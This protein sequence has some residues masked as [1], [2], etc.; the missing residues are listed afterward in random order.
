MYRR[1]NVQ[2]QSVSSP[3]ARASRVLRRAIAALALGLLVGVF[4]SP[5]AGWA[6]GGHDAPAGLTLP[7]D[8][9]GDSPLVP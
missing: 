4:A 8:G 2:L 7:S 1:Q 6:A 5:T 3:A 9:I